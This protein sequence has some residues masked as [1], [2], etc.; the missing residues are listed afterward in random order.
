MTQS[1][2]LEVR[3]FQNEMFLIFQLLVSGGESPDVKRVNNTL[4]AIAVHM[5][6]CQ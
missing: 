2:V 3:L 4:I 1:P 6:E 5:T